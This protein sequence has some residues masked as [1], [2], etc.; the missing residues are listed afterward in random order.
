MIRISA[1][2][3]KYK[4]GSYGAFAKMLHR[5]LLLINTYFIHWPNICD[6]LIH[7]ILYPR[8]SSVILDKTQS[9]PQGLYFLARTQTM[10]AVIK[11]KYVGLHLQNSTQFIK[12]MWFFETETWCKL[13]DLNWETAYM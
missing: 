2:R 7:D 13:H 1:W 9:H 6:A 11:I 10:K 4:E 3:K 5:N 12:L 8:N